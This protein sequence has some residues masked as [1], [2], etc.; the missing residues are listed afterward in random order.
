MRQFHKTS[1]THTRVGLTKTTFICKVRVR[2]K[3][4]SWYY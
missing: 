3:I 2:S 4:I 1:F